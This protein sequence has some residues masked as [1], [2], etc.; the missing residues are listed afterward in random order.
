MLN[1]K[2]KY[3]V[4]YIS[5]AGVVA[6]TL[7]VAYSNTGIVRD[8]SLMICAAVIGIVISTIVNIAGKIAPERLIVSLL[9][10]IPSAVALVIVILYYRNVDRITA[11]NPIAY[12]VIADFKGSK[13]TGAL[14]AF[15]LPFSMMSD[16]SQNMASK[17]WYERVHSDPQSGGFLRIHYLLVPIKG[18]EGYVG[19]YADFTPPPAKPVSLLAYH[20]ISFRVRIDQETSNLPEIRLVLYSDNIKNMEYAYPIARVQPDKQWRNY[21]IPFSKFE[22]P[23]HALSNVELKPGRVYRFAFVLVSDNEIHG[24]LDIDEIKLF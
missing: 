18:R 2:L 23:P 7:Y 10:L 16:S 21:D 19:I 24:H 12:N 3:I 15:G 13:G 14:T 6:L 17:V 9:I 11:P 22:S 8:A 5:A 1:H 20:G 4:G